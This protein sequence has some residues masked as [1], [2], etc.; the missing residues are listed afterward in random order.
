[1]DVE[2]QTL[3]AIYILRLSHIWRN[4]RKIRRGPSIWNS[5]RFYSMHAL[6]GHATSDVG[7]SVDLV[8]H[9]SFLAKKINGSSLDQYIKIHRYPVNLHVLVVTMTIASKIAMQVVSISDR[10]EQ[11]FKSMY[12]QLDKPKHMPTVLETR[13]RIPRAAM[14]LQ[15]RAMILK[16]VLFPSTDQRCY[17]WTSNTL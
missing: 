17:Q 11:Q 8:C 1:M 13:V 15:M 5:H 6:Y 4:K 10:R 3:D 16:M 9:Y 12:I 2:M 7:Y 14:I